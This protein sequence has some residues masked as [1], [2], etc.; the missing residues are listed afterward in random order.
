VG[1]HS[2][3]EVVELSFDTDFHSFRLLRGLRHAS[4][5]W[6]SVKMI[7]AEELVR[8]N[9]LEM[10]LTKG[11]H[12]RM[13]MSESN[14]GSEHMD[15]EKGPASLSL[16]HFM[17]AFRDVDGRSL[18]HIMAM[19]DMSD[20][21]KPFLELDARTRKLLEMSEERD[22][23]IFI[24]LGMKNM[25]AFNAL[26]DVQRSEI[27]KLKDRNGR[28][29]LHVAA[30]LDLRNTCEELLKCGC[31]VSQMDHFGRL[32]MEIA[33]GSAR[34]LL[35]CHFKSSVTII[36]TLTGQRKE[37]S[38]SSIPNS[39]MSSEYHPSIH[40]SIHF[41]GTLCLTCPIVIPPLSTQLSI[42]QSKTCA[43]GSQTNSRFLLRKS[44]FCGS[45]MPSSSSSL[46][47]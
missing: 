6:E 46:V 8:R 13:K 27:S 19:L 5:R 36:S 38:F 35:Q 26:L 32:P 10:E 28:S 30:A 25:R 22:A 2:P 14:E 33:K 21:I 41:L 24:A 17:I 16:E 44:V 18:L 47:L 39:S 45:R 7:F 40:P 42:I 20:P 15:I 12:K 11:K 31:A 1:L 37:T 43:C 3:R 29:L 34:E 9:K 4:T 23:P